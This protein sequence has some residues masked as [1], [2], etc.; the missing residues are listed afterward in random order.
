VIATVGAI[1]ATFKALERVQ[2]VRGRLERAAIT[3]SGAPVYVDYAHTPTGSRRRSPHSAA[4]TG[5][6]IVVSAPAA[7]AIA[8]SA[9]D[10]RDRHRQRPIA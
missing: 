9:G 3:R 5:Q 7:T 8:A 6:L 1:E 2:P 4:H 10:G